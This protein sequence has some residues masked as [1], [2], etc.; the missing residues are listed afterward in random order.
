MR[1]SGNVKHAVI[2]LCLLSMFGWSEAQ[3][4]KGLLE[5]GDRFFLKK[6]YQNALKTYQEILAVETGDPLVYFK[7]GVS[8]LNQEN[9]SQAV[10]YLEKAYELKPDVDEDIAY[11]MGMAYQKDHQFKKAG[12]QFET[13]SKKN[14]RLLPIALKK[15]RECYVADSLMRIKVQADVS[16][17]AEDI[18]TAFSDFAPLISQDGKTLVFTSDRSVDGYQIKSGTNAGD[19]YITEKRG[20][21]W[22]PARKIGDRINVKLHESATAMSADSKTLLLFYEE[23]NG[24]IYLSTREDNGWS[25]PAALNKFINHPQ[26]RESFACL[27]A[28]GNRLYFSS[29]RPGG[30]GG[31][32]IYVSEMGAN[33]QWGRPSNLGSAINT[34][35]DEESPFITANGDALYF[36]SDGH[37]T[38]GE[39]DILRSRLKDGKWNRPDNLG[40]PIN[41]SGYEGQFSLSAD[42]KIGYFA[43]RRS[44]HAD[45]LNIYQVDFHTTSSNMQSGS[46]TSVPDDQ[47][48]KQI[49]TLLRGTVVDV[50][51]GTPITATL[52]LVDNSTNTVLS[53][54]VTDASGNFEIIMPREGNYGVTAVRNGYLF[55][56]LN[57]NLPP[58]QKY[59]EIDTHILMIKAEVGSKIVLK[60]I[61]F[62]ANEAALKPES[63]PE[64]QNIL[65]LLTQNPRWGIQINGHTDNIDPRERNVALSLRRAEAVVE[66]LVRE[67][68]SADRLEAKGFGPDRPLVSNDDEKDGRQLNRRTEIEIISQ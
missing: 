16:I 2:T 5:K 29:N 66:Y 50:T 35:G 52:S 47:R 24:D 48:G 25:Q 15:I 67:G 65:E 51:D 8:S 23:G 6:D 43:S 19:V 12:E 20:S 31:F 62:D 44:P 28:D 63:F 61:F 36:S 68:I 13:L 14:K 33:G 32:D 30:K 37:G 57:F 3:S 41:T 59:Q 21:S 34:R 7:A 49:V 60:N 11:H 55:N 38:L 54:V 4:V 1:E 22:A 56:S 58:F 46:V 27:S 17:L 53:D 45:N 10:A 26:Y 9:Y 39:K 18:N 64:L 40:Y 42:G